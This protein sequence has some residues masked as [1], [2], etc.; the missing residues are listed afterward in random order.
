M[1]IADYASAGADAGSLHPPP[2]E[3]TPG[4]D[5]PQ[6]DEKLDEARRFAGA[7]IKSGRHWL[8]TPMGC[9]KG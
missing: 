1:R 6:V 7:R 9:A 5:E 2:Q 8:M 4:G 3:Q